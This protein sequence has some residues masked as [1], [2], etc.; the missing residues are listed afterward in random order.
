MHT[1]QWS[2]LASWDK[3]KT[4]PY[5]YICIYLSWPPIKLLPNPHEETRNPSTFPGPPT[6]PRP[7]PPPGLPCLKW[8]CL[9][10]GSI[11]VTYVV[12]DTKVVLDEW[13]ASKHRAEYLKGW[14]VLTGC[15]PTHFNSQSNMSHML[16]TGQVSPVIHFTQCN[17]N[18]TECTIES[19][20]RKP[21][22][23]SRKSGHYTLLRVL[24]LNEKA[25]T[26]KYGLDFELAF[27]ARGRFSV[28]NLISGK[29]LLTFQ[30]SCH[31]AKRWKQ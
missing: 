23:E 2:T 30:F 10:R 8:K 21:F 31:Q 29:T 3:G 20:Q 14:T 18:C 13:L 4:P 11:T 15:S 24:I 27:L 22:V 9:G 26:S 6:Y 25:N 28:T 19:V 16:K 12:M 17:N 7:L 5:M 1:C